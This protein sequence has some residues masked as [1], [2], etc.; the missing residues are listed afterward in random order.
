MSE[1]D[2][3]L[4]TDKEMT[5]AI[6]AGWLPFEEES[7]THDQ[8]LTLR[9]QSIAKAQ[10]AK[11]K[12]H[13]EQKKLDRPKLGNDIVRIVDWQFRQITNL[14]P[15]AYARSL[16]IIKKQIL[17]L[18][19]KEKLMIEGYMEMAKEAAVKEA[20]KQERERIFKN[21]EGIGLN[22]LGFVH[23]APEEW[24]ALKEEK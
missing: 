8:L 4:L 11:V 10:L 13:Y 12:Q 23:L 18:F 22:D 6:Q 16:K 2:E 9:Y 21:I 14:L 7:M 20:K 1:Q 3:L 19:E 15:S 5:K 24:Q 17:A